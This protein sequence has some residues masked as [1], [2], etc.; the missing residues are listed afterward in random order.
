MIILN[1]TR[2]GLLILLMRALVIVTAFRA[3]TQ[4]SETHFRFC[5]PMSQFMALG[6]TP[7]PVTAGLQFAVMLS[8]NGNAISPNKFELQGDGWNG[9]INL[10]LS[11]LK[12]ASGH[13]TG[14]VKIGNGAGAPIEGVRLDIRIH[15]MKTSAFSIKHN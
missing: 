8:D 4:Q 12:F 1:E 10:G 13:L 14:D 15:A 6:K 5:G 9:A 7:A 11:N 2:I 3:H